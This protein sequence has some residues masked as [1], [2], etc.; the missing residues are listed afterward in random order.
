ML[1]HSFVIASALVGCSDRAAKPRPEPAPEEPARPAAV[2]VLLDMLDCSKV[3]TEDLIPTW[4]PGSK[5]EHDRT[6]DEYGTSTDCYYTMGT[7]FGHVRIDCQNTP[8]SDE[9]IR[10]NIKAFT[11]ATPV[12]GIGRGADQF[13]RRMIRFWHRVV[14]KCTIEVEITPDD[15]KLSEFAKEIDRRITALGHSVGDPSAAK[16]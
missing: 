12:D 6:R 2:P 11:E 13:D 8:W 3:A 7:R 15:P 9:D 16:P 1:G 14:P 4:F 10:A 5:L